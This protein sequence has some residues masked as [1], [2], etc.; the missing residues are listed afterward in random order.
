[1]AAAP[2]EPT[3]VNDGMTHIVVNSNDK[4]V[5][6]TLHV[7]LD[8]KSL[9]NLVRIADL[10]MLGLRGQLEVASGLGHRN[11][12]AKAVKRLGESGGFGPGLLPRKDA[13]WAA[14]DP[15]QRISWMATL[16][17][18]LGQE[19]LY[20]QY[21]KKDASW[22]DR[23]NWMAAGT[24]IPEFLDPSY[25]EWARRAAYPGV[26][27]PLGGTHFV[28]IAGVGRGAAEYSADNPLAG[29]FGYDRVTS[30]EEIRKNRGLANT[31]VMVQV[32][33][34]GPAGITPWMAGGGSTLRG[35]PETD[36][37]KPFVIHSANGKAGTYLLMADGSV[38][39]V[40]A[41]VKDEVFKAL[42][43][44]KGSANVANLDREAPALKTGK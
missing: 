9:P 11:S 44:I 1:M 26:P 6:F 41:D 40:G 16:L 21:I 14:R 17:P 36:S 31:A 3:K 27:F 25:P 35:L 33:Y 10:M 24:I 20:G 29:V 2:K 28:G 15:E 13:S 5:V 22:K 7:V 30:L 38:R 8:D 37:V 34:D 32:P 23:A 19:T 4:S 39:F 43:T 42:C 18:Y 12:L